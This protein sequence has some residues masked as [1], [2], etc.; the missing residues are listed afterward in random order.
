MRFVE[1]EDREFWFSMDSHARTGEFA[2]KVRDQR[3][4]V[5]LAAGNPAGILHYSLFWDNLP[6]LNLITILPSF[7]G[8]GYGR[9]AMAQWETDMKQAGFAMTLVST[10]VDEDAQ[11]FYRKLGYR[12]CG[13]LLLQ[14]C[15][16]A[17]PMELFL[18]K[19]LRP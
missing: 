10:Q 6:F 17:Q 3:G 2:K 16:L 18:C 8:K 11:H 9:A 13:C 1:E 14:D 15:P 7:R 4:Y 19:T 12:D 5:L